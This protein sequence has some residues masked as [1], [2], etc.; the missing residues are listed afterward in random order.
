MEKYDESI[1]VAL[2]HNY[3]DIAKKIAKL[4]DDKKI[5]KRLWLEV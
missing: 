4:V 2:E 5:Q 3:L 1:K